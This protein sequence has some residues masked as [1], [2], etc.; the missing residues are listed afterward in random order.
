MGYAITKI[1]RLGVRQQAAW[2]T[3]LSPGATPLTNFLEC[4]MP[5]ITLQDEAISMDTLRGNFYQPRILNGSREGTTISFSCYLHGAET[6]GSSPT[7]DLTALSPSG[8]LLAAALG[9][10][11][12]FSGFQ[13]DQEGGGA[14]DTISYGTAPTADMGGAVLV[15]LTGGGNGVGWVKA[16][17]A[18]DVT[19]ISDLPAPPLV[20]APPGIDQYGSGVAVLR[21]ATPLP[22]TLLWTSSD[23]DSVIQ[24]YDAV[25][26][27][28]KISI[29]PKEVAKL[30]IDMQCGGYTIEAAGGGALPQFT[31]PYPVIPAVLKT[32]AT[33]P[34]SRYIVNSVEQNLS[35]LELTITAEY[36]KALSYNGPEGLSEYVCS[37]RDIALAITKPIETS[38]AAEADVGPGATGAG[39]IQLDINPNE[40][41]NVFSLLIPAPVLT[42]QTS[43]GDA[44]GLIGI[45]Q[46]W[47]CTI[48][49]GDATSVESGNTPFRV[50][51]L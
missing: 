31:Y 48:Y 32:T 18:T 35:T 40:P 33:A 1:G 8:R 49:A 29:N 36:A 42:E 45:T 43:I 30:D 20:T 23:G 19:L 24:F 27:S 5:S 9:A 37:N 6:S 4:E 2:G 41:G 17:G 46:N 10:T 12:A 11:P 22:F 7:A 44:E 16:T 34:N 15:A 25:V 3:A 28:A 39:T 51:F 47:G 13:S 21:T 14:L 50:A 26:T 38:A